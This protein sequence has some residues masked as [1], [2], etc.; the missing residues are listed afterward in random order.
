MQ[1]AY[2]SLAPSLT[3]AETVFTSVSMPE[4]SSGHKEHGLL[5]SHPIAYPIVSLSD[6]KE[7]PAAI[8]ECKVGK[9]IAI[10][11]GVHFEYNHDAL[12]LNKSENAIIKKKLKATATE[13][14]KLFVYIMSQ[15]GIKT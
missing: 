10:L 8:V 6:I 7:N 1:Q 12:N 15:L 13:R 14:K 3:R 4:M 5:S 2:N 11:S 9:G